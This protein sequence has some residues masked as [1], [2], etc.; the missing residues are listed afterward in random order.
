[1]PEPRRPPR[2]H[3]TLP[4]GRRS[5]WLLVAVL[6]ALAALGAWRLLPRARPPEVV[7]EFHGLPAVDL[8][9][10]FFPDRLAFTA[11]SPPPA[12]ARTTVAVPGRV[13][14]GADL[15]PGEAIVRYAAPGIGAGYR[16][17][18][19]GEP[20]A[21]IVLRA[22]GTVAGR[23]VE[24]TGAW[25]FGWRCAELRPV[26]G[27]EVLVMGG[28]EHGIELARVR[29]DQDGRFAIGG[30]DLGLDGLG[31]R[32]R[33]PGFAL[34]HAPLRAG[35]DVPLAR[36]A[37]HRGRVRLPPEVDPGSL[38]VLARGLPGVEAGLAPDGGFVLDHVPDGLRPRLLVHGLPPAWAQLPALLQP[39]LEIDVVA[40]ATVRGRVV[41]AA[42]G[43]PLAGALVLCGDTAAARSDASGRF[44]LVQLPPGPATIEAK[45]E[46]GT[47]RRRTTRS[48]TKAVPL[49]RG[50]TVDE[51]LVPI[52]TEP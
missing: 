21:P 1:M 46:V 33:A 41:E 32:V 40:A 19:L 42:T 39:E 10:T 49:R 43:E 31:L 44:E 36:S 50:E 6:L 51:V 47:G 30:V 24:P 17:V 25:A 38:R 15:V 5:W 2:R 18:R 13:R 9:L 35:L 52:A 8:E 7:L 16:H 20:V 34:A 27:A 22:P 26:A 28:G 37:A 12:L 29:S 23:V 11:P 4:G 48:G 3:H 45:V 14:F